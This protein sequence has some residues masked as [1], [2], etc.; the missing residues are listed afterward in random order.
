M[1][2]QSKRWLSVAA[3]RFLVAMGFVVKSVGSVWAGIGL[4]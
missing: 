2:F 3:V 4:E 1:D